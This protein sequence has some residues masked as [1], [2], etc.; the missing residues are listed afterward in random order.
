MVFCRRWFCSS[1]IGLAG[2]R[3]KQGF[4]S[5]A[6]QTHWQ[7]EYANS[8]PDGSYAFG[9]GRNAATL[10]RQSPQ[11]YMEITETCAHKKMERDPPAPAFST[12]NHDFPNM[13]IA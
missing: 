12:I 3:R 5:H 4:A 2:K 10:K 6:W 9:V 11:F 7:S 1:G 13:V 8:I